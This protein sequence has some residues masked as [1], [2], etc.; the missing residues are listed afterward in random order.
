[1]S[2]SA[3]RDNATKI[4]WDSYTPPVA[5]HVGV[6]RVD[7]GIDVLR[8]YI[9]WTPFFMT[10][11]LAGKY[12][13]ILEDEVVGDEAKRLFADANAMLDKLSDEKA[14]TPRGVVGL[15]PAN[16]V[17]DDIH[18][19]ADEQRD[20]LN[21]SHH[22]RQQTE[23]RLCQLL[24]GR[25]CGAESSG[26]ADYIGAFAVTGGLEEMRWPRLTISWQDD[27]NKIMVKAIAD[28]LAEAFAEYLHE[29]VRKT[30][31]GLAPD[32][33]TSV[34]RR[35]SA[36]II[37]AFARRRAIRPVRNTLRKPLSGRCWMWKRTRV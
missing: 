37:R 13:R 10:W 21:I 23:N 18:I 6:R 25:F 11:S 26:K 16:R 30:I 19:F 8:N 31:W 4:D 20:T 7:A 14:L 2:L 12:P 36:K 3:A 33:S 24:S 9:D 22:L 35:S 29:Q 32:E 27:Y 5:K 28:R 17:G 34:M 1:M 15:F